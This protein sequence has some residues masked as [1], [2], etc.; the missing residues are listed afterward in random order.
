M[1]VLKYTIVNIAAKHWSSLFMHHFKWFISVFDK[2]LCHFKNSWPLIFLR[3]INNRPFSY[4][5]PVIFL[6]EVILSDFD[7]TVLML[8]RNQ[9]FIYIFFLPVLWIPMQYAGQLRIASGVH[10]FSRLMWE[11]SLLFQKLFFSSRSL[12]G[13]W[14]SLFDQCCCPVLHER[15]RPIVYTISLCFYLWPLHCFM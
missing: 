12:S 13:T 6:L 5:F 9:H 11:L 1:S 3:V 10:M 15:H 4:Y 2:C 8:S 14:F 7:L